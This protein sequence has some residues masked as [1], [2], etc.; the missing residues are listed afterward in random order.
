MS[1][2]PFEYPINTTSPGAVGLS[3][4]VTTCRLAVLEANPA[5]DRILQIDDVRL[6]RTHRMNRWR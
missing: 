5:L 3:S 6:S 4:A 1:G 2:D